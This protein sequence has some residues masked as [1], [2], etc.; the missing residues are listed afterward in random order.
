MGKEFLVTTMNRNG[1]SQFQA[2]FAVDDEHDF[3]SQLK[4]A[5]D[6]ANKLSGSAK[7]VLVSFHNDNKTIAERVEFSG[8]KACWM[9]GRPTSEYRE[10]F[11]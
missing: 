5:V 10:W 3:D 9:N 4:R 6:R 8:L 7:F 11:V 2:G 1:E